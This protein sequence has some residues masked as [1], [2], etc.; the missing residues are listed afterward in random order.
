MNEIAQGVA[1]LEQAGALHED[2]GPFAAEV[3]AAGH[4]DRLSFTAD[5]D[6]RQ[7]RVGGQGRVPS[8]EHAVGHPDDVRDAAAFQGRRH[9]GA[10]EHDRYSGRCA[11]WQVMQAGSPILA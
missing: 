1:G 6:Q 8:A 10:V 7:V 11:L 5:A 2:D 3:Q 9:R 4:G